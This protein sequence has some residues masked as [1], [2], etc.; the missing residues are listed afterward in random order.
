MTME[1]H[2]LVSICIPTLGRAKALTR[3]LGELAGQGYVLNSSVSHLLEVCVSDNASID[4][5][6]L[7]LLHYK[8]LIPNFRTVRQVNRV[9]FPENLAAAM[10]LATG[11]F[12]WI[13]GDDDQVM[14]GGIKRVLE[15]LGSPLNADTNFVLINEAE[16]CERTG[17]FLAQRD[18]NK[19]RIYAP[20]HTILEDSTIEN[21]GHISRIILRRECISMS[22]YE[23]RRS[24]DLMPFLRWIV[25]AIAEGR[26]DNIGETLIIAHYVADNPHWRGRWMYCYTCELPELIRQI[27]LNC[28]LSPGADRRLL[29][30]KR[31]LKA[32]FQIS[33]LRDDHHDG[34]VFARAHHPREF[35]P[36][37][38]ARFIDLVWSLTYMRRRGIQLIRKFKPSFGQAV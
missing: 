14:P 5:T 15:Y 24:W 20:N 32:Y 13:M 23:E 10:G 37:L 4:D 6:N 16:F 29:P 3:L 36:Y 26:H 34:W 31:Y 1:P 9:G 17:C 25:A 11:R 19:T 38:V 35:F 30:V 2:V 21:L 33:L 22:L 8:T 12:I 18:C 28:T 27:R 7:V